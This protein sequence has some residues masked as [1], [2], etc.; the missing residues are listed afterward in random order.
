[1]LDKNVPQVMEIHEAVQM[2]A[3][4]KKLPKNKKR[5]GNEQKNNN[6]GYLKNRCDTKDQWRIKMHRVIL[7]GK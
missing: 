7:P 1:M 5:K 4:L 2:W 6:W 3:S